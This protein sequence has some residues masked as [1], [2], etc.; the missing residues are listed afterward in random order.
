[1]LV[2]VLVLV[3]GFTGC[4]EDED[5]NENEDEGA[6]ELAPYRTNNRRIAGFSALPLALG[7]GSLHHRLAP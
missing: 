1:L 3:L 7:L 4:F 2:L 5:E 6:F